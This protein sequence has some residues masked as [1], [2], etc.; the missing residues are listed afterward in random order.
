MPRENPSPRAIN[1]AS[2]C[3]QHKAALRLIR[4]SFDAAKT[5]SSAIGVYVALTEIASDE[6]AEVF[7]TTHAWIALK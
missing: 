4:D 5:V 3:W 2:F 6:Q 1:D 7:V